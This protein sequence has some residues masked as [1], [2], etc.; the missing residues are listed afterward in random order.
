MLPVQTKSTRN[1]SVPAGCGVVPAAALGEEMRACRPETDDAL[2]CLA[3]AQ[4]RRVEI[5]ESA[6]DN[7]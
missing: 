3:T 7:G 1:V 5:D 2:P 6:A 4:Q